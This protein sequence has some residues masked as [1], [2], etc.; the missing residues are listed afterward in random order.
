MLRLGSINNNKEEKEII[1]TT[2]RDFVKS[3]GFK[4]PVGRF[5]IRFIF[6]PQRF[7]GA[8]VFMVET[9]DKVYNVKKTLKKEELKSLVDFIGLNK[10]A[11]YDAKKAVFVIDESGVFG[12]DVC[13]ENAFFEFKGWGWLVREYKEVVSNFDDT[14][15]F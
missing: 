14:I 12:I 8:I 4:L 6:L 3:F 10:K 15:D 1:K 9:D 7:N 11:N 2:W 5:P 13:E